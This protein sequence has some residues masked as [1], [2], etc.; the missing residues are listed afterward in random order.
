MFDVF[1]ATNKV[2]PCDEFCSV[3]MSA[4]CAATRQPIAAQLSLKTTCFPVRTMN[5]TEIKSLI[6]ALGFVCKG[7]DQNVFV[8]RYPNHG[9]YSLKIDF[10]NK[11]LSYGSDIT[12]SHQRVL[13]FEDAENFVVL[14]CVDRLLRK[15]YQPKHLE[16]ERTF[17]LGHT[18]VAGRADITVKD[19]RGKTLFV[20]ECKTFGE[21]Y[22]HAKRKL[23]TKRRPAF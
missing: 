16:L 6:S 5:V 4:P 20:V 21:E 17:P 18:P 3:I 12:V 14:E 8:K 2:K 1:S 11:R 15:G 7:K 22:E 9:Q 23:Q 10:Q 19:R 13:G